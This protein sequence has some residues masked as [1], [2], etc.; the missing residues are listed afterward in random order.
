MFNSEN[1]IKDTLLSCLNQTYDN[2]EVIIVND[3]S[4]DKGESVVSQFVDDRIRYFKIDNSGA[5]VARNLGISHARGEVV[6]FLDADDVLDKDKIHFQLLKYREYGDE[7]VYSSNMGTVK[8][9]AFTI[10]EGYELYQQDFE[11]KA[12]FRN[13]VNQFGKYLTTGAWLIPSRIVHSI[14]GWDEKI[15]L[16]QDGEYMMRVILQSK[17]IIYCEKSN[18]Y[19]RRDVKDSVSKKRNKAIFESWLYSYLSYV[20]N[21]KKSFDNNTANELGWKALSVYYCSSYPNHP[22]LLKKCKEHMKKL[23]YSTPNAHGGKTFK[24]I[25]NYIGTDN[26]LK[27]FELKKKMMRFFSF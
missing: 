9:N 11:P 15:K 8:G 27:I 22:D 4:T 18:F 2:I 3:G 17:G 26:A 25:A 6:Q 24:K 13:L 7:Y 14:N 23:G 5:C 16:N 1:L 19:Y 10:D 20:D 21:F 12:Y